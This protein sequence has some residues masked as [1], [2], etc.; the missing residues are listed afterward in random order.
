MKQQ[1]VRFSVPAFLFCLILFSPLWTRA[2]DNL[3]LQD[4]CRLKGQ[5][6]NH[7]HGVGLVVGLRGTGDEGS[8]PTSR[9]L[10]SLMHHMGSQF[11]TDAQGVP[12]LDE[13][14]KAGN[15]ALV[16]VNADIPAS[17]AQQGDRFD[18]TISSI[19]SK[20]LEGGTLI[21]T[22]LLGPR[23]DDP[24]VY[25]LAQGQL[26][27]PD[28]RTPTS[29]VIH[30]GCKM[31]STVRNQY[32]SQDHKV[33]LVL[34]QGQST[35]QTA[36]T[37]E[38]AINELMQN[39]LGGSPGSAAVQQSATQKMAQAIDQHHIEV[40][41]PNF[42]R[43]VPVQFVSLLMGISIK[44]IQKRKSVYINERE[45]VIAVGDDVLISPVA[46]SHKNLV[47]A[48]GTPRGNFV[49]VDP[50]SPDA[51]NVRAKLKNLQ[52]ALNALSVPTDDFISIIKALK[53]KGDLYGEVIIE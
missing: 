33:T 37:V 7:L 11:S 32:V 13:I 39:M 34:D 35:F 44:N 43:D 53:A 18:C 14:K 52:E 38:E 25:A 31:E 30:K 4:I 21:L 50:A 1:K 48:A 24:K 45:G 23:P 12:N 49:G 40:V 46:I 42:Y 6:V 9:A 28:P 3:T 10:V 19:S 47:I 41:I 2:D 26:T 8:R 20:N 51:P 15:V 16:F 36:Q 27:I 22:S 29:A 17:G 5:E